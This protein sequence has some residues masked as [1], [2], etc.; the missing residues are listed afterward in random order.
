MAVASLVLGI[1]SICF[2]PITGIIGG[3]LGIL[4]MSKPSGKGMAMAGM[5]TSA[6]FSVAWIVLAVWGFLWAKDSQGRYQDSRSLM[7]LGLAAHNYHDVTNELPPPFVR[8][9]GE[10]PGQ[11]VSDLND[12]L[13][14]RVSILPYIEQDSLY[15]QFKMNEPWNSPTNM[16]LGNTAIKTFSDTDTPTD[17]NTR[18]RCFYD[19]GAM[20]DTRG[21][22]SI[23]SVTDG[24]SNTIMYVEGGDKV[25]WSR[26][27]VAHLHRHRAERSGGGDARLVPHLQ[28]LCHLERKL[29]VRHSEQFAVQPH[30]RPGRHL[31]H[32]PHRLVRVQRP[33]AAE[34]PAE[35]HTAVRQHLLLPRRAEGHAVR[36]A[37]AW[38]SG[39]RSRF[40]LTH[41]VSR[42]HA[43]PS[44]WPIDL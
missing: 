24:T 17:P 3:I 5:G 6:L 20:F 40:P 31:A 22:V 1:L 14:W 4:G 19:N 29:R 25:T 42:R 37:H 8:R 23:S 27:Q 2:G 11:P 18:F 43:F 35:P 15:R 34:P 39:V 12:R 38:P 44:D 26:F 10:V 13:S 21:R 32:Q 16:P 9:P 33:R 30:F 28:L 41:S 36:L 7:Q